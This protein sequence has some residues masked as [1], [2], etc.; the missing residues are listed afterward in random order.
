M[1]PFKRHSSSTTGFM[2]L[3]G[4]LRN[5]IYALAGVTQGN[6]FELLPL[7]VP[8]NWIQGRKDA[9]ETKTATGKEK[10]GKAREKAAEAG[11]DEEEGVEKIRKYKDVAAPLTEYE[12]AAAE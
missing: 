10:C 3:P 6:I 12:R 11:E 8:C 4:E 7:P 5:E 1:Y 9:S 2:D